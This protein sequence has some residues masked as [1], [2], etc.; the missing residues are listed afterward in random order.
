MQA[1]D[2][3]NAIY[4]DWVDY[5]GNRLL[6]LAKAAWVANYDKKGAIEAGNY[7]SMIEPDAACYPK[8]EALFNEIKAKSIEDWKFELKK[9]QDGVDLEKMRISAW[10]SV[11]VAY[12]NHQQPVTYNTAWL[13]GR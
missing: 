4:K 1:I 5:E 11:G 3:G 8:V 7:L 6:S 2:A 13:Y 12:G 10:Q 9:Y